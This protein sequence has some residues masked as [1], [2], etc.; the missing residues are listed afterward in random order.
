MST[1]SSHE[2]R[3]I[4]NVRCQNAFISLV[5]CQCSTDLPRQGFRW[6]QDGRYLF[7]GAVSSAQ[8]AR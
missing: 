6:K 7:W 4:W 3:S 2:C 5:P 1:L 8:H